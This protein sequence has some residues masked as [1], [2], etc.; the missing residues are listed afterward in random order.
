[1]NRL[2]ATLYLSLFV[3]FFIT[4]QSVLSHIPYYHEQHHLFLYSKA[5]FLETFHTFGFLEYITTFV[6]QFFYYPLLGSLILSSLLVSLYAM[7]SYSSRCISKNTDYIHIGM[8]VSIYLFL[9]TMS[10]DISVS[11][12]ISWFIVLLAVSLALSLPQKK[13][14]YP[15]CLSAL[16]SLLFL[17]SW[18]IILL[19]ILVITLSTSSGYMMRKMKNKY[20]TMITFAVTVI[21]ALTGF[22]YF[23]Y[24]Y[25]IS[26]RRMIQAY[27]NMQ[28]R[29]W[30]EVLKITENHL[31]PGRNNQ[32]MSYYRNIALY[33]TG[34]LNQRLFDIPQVYGMKTLYLPWQSDSR[35]TEYGRTVYMELG[36]WNEA[37]R[38]AFEAMTVWGETAPIL[39]DL[40]E[41]NIKTGRYIVAQR[42]INILKQSLFYRKEAKNLEKG[43]LEIQNE[44]LFPHMEKPIRFSN[45]FNIEPELEYLCNQNPNNKMAVEYYMNILLLSNQVVRF[46]QNLY[47]MDIFENKHY[48]DSF[49]EALFLYKIGDEKGFK[50]LDINIDKQTEKRFKQYYTLYKQ[51]NMERLK[52]QYGNTYWYYIHFI[53][54]YGNKIINQ[55]SET[56]NK[57]RGL[58]H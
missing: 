31:K 30:E 21:Y 22:Y 39:T 7:L 25:N 40:A 32:L 27:K 13:W 9:K 19:S 55:E 6:I 54:P 41:L 36:H 44:P 57:G 46:A 18:K 49:E 12:L 37:H 52:R 42:F 43:I 4:Y 29:N 51:M 15:V 11:L 50:T 5:Y 47:R 28:N 53:S 38:W 17:V 2:S 48:P 14:R 20:L 33:H 1:M 26:E 24:S 56:E 34:E 8:L 10:V 45:I 16:L 23:Y 35:E 3:I 58:K